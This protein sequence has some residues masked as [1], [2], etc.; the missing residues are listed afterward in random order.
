ML[1]GRGSA[2]GAR[3][4]WGSRIHVLIRNQQYFGVM[5]K[6]FFLGA[7]LVA[8]ASQPSKAQTGVGDVVVVRIVEGSTVYVTITRGVGKS[9]QLEF[10]NN[11]HGKGSNS[12]VESYYQ[13]VSKLYQEGYS[14]K[15]T[16]A[17]GTGASTILIFVKGQ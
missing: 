15:S 5:K 3:V 11:Y 8:L 17:S 1:A 13:F 6:L 4:V 10:A 2:A 12:T 9:E 14:L 7:C 16:I